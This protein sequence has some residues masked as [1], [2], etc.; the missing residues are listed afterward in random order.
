MFET[1]QLLGLGTAAGIDTLLLLVLLEPRNRRFAPAPVLAITFGVWLWHAGLVALLLLLM[2]ADEWARPIQSLSLLVA[3]A[4]ALLTPSAMLHCLARL[5]HTGLALRAAP[6]PRHL[7]AYVPLLA[8]PFCAGLAPA[9]AANPLSPLADCVVPYLVWSSAVNLAAGATFLRCAHHID[10]APAR[11]FFTQLGVL[12]LLRTALHLGVYLVVPDEPYARLVVYLTPMLSMTL[13]GY[14]VLRHNFLYL[15][16]DRGTLYAGIV[17]TTFL[18]HQ[19]LFVTLTA[20]MSTQ[21]RVSFIVVETVVLL[22][23]ILAVPSWRQRCTEALRYLLGAR[24]AGVRSR[25]RELAAELAARS[26]AKPLETL[27]WFVERLRAALEVEF[28]AGW[29]FDGAGRLRARCGT[30]KRFAE[31]DVR[32]LVEGMQATRLD[33]CSH[34]DAP[35]REAASWLQSAAASLAI[36]KSRRN[37]TGL[38]LLGRHTRNRDL[39][40]EVTGAVL[41]LVEELVIKLDN[42]LL[43]A[44]RLDAERRALHG[45]K[46]AALGLL[47]GSVAHEVKNPLSAIKTIATVLAEDLGAASPHAED[48]RLI[49]GEV[50]RLAATTTQLLDFAR[51]RAGNGRVG[52]VAAALDGTLGV[53]RHLARQREIALDVNIPSELPHVQA[54]DQALREIFFNL[55]SNA[56]DAAGPGGRVAVACSSVDG[57]LVTEVRDTGCGV[58]LALRERLFEPFVTTKAQGT[59]LG[60]HVVGRRVQELGGSIRCDGAPETG[61]VFTVRLPILGPLE[62]DA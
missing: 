59:G 15:T 4:G 46:L 20:D 14:F 49:L 6:D 37:L 39:S 60:L 9:S 27:D 58:P 34:R 5:W 8:L 53:L 61:A 43:L 22:S 51:P 1:V 33:A 21:A 31:A 26:D 54:D 56:L 45:E 57:H 52:C 48:L 62:T 10:F 38:L 42:S 44:E 18:L 36:V 3:C 16:L 30:A 11:P 41:L 28:V 12:A 55:L 32:L 50:E 23:L 25:L 47:A 35:S 40:A 29:L 13:F 19:F 2:I 24:V 7:L 17:A